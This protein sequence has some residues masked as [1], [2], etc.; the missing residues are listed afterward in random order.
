MADA[1]RFVERQH[2]HQKRS[3]GPVGPPVLA[4]DDRGV[5]MNLLSDVTHEVCRTVRQCVQNR[6]VARCVVG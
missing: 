5:G 1:G 3:D 2:V 4:T 6:S